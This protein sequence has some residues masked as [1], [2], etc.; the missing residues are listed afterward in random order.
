M[1]NCIML[2]PIASFKGQATEQKSNVLFFE[3]EIEIA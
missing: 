1:Y 2:Q 3:T